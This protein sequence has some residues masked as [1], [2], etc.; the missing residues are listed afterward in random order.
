MREICISGIVAGTI[1]VHKDGQSG[2]PSVIN[3]NLKDMDDAL[4]D[5]V[6]LSTT[7]EATSCAAT[8]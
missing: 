6:G 7:R 2:C 3:K 1:K 8:L 4:T 5:S